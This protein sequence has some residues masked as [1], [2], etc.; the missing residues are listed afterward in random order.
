MEFLTEGLNMYKKAST[1]NRRSQP[2]IITGSVVLLASIV[3]IL[4][5]RSNLSMILYH[6][7]TSLS[8]NLFA[9]HW[10]QLPGLGNNNEKLGLPERLSAGIQFRFR[11]L[12]HGKNIGGVYFFYSIWYF[13][14]SN[15]LCKPQG[16]LCSS[17]G[18]HRVIPFHSQNEN[19]NETFLVVIIA[20]LF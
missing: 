4:V 17:P 3:S 13:P 7:T 20:I 8:R 14:W 19:Y 2:I 15:E 1:Y 9:W 6:P 18:L 12:F 10:L 11:N 5:V 16:P